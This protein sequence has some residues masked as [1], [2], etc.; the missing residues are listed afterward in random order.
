MSSEKKDHGGDGEIK[1]EVFPL[2]PDVA[3]QAA[4]PVK[5]VVKKINK[6][7]QNND[8]YT[9]ND[10]VFTCLLIHN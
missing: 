10:D 2:H 4:D 8:G 6:Y 5:F 7:T 1:T 9:G 3:R